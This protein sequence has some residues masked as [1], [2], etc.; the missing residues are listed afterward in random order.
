MFLQWICT[1]KYASPL[2]TRL[3]AATAYWFGSYIIHSNIFLCNFW[4][5]VGIYHNQTLHTIGILESMQ[6]LPLFCK[7]REYAIFYE[8][9]L[10]SVTSCSIQHSLGALV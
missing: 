2:P 10:V 6:S 8:L 7:L 4:A 3:C 1:T 5:D 9:D